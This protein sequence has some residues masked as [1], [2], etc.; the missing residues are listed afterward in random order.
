MTIGSPLGVSEVQSE[1][2]PGFSFKD[3]YPEK[4]EHWSNYF[5]RLDPVALDAKL[6][7]D[8]KKNGE[9]VIHDVQV[10]NSGRWRHTATDYLA[11]ADFVQTLKDLLF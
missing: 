1:L 8:F 4:V 2:G 9:E 7:N 6:A 11:Q 5:D 3:G 10:Y